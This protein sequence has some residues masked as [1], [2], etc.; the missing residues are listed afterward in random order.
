MTVLVYFIVDTY[1]IFVIIYLYLRMYH[2]D[3]RM[4]HDV[5][6]RVKILKFI[7]DPNFGLC[8]ILVTVT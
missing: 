2:L 5:Y 3:L 7:S 1:N 4:N 8:T 6:I